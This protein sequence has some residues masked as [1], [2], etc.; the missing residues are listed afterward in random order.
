MAEENF[1][2]PSLHPN[3]QTSIDGENL[4]RNMLFSG[5]FISLR[6]QQSTFYELSGKQV[7]EVQID[8]TQLVKN[9]LE[10]EDN[11]IP[12]VLPPYH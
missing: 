8:G 7:E 2:D 12:Y 10:T 6:Q 1:L 3:Y 4:H 5:I 9:F 11:Q